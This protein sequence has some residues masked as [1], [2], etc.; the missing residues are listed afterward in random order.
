MQMYEC[1][2]SKFFIE[3][4]LFQKKL[5]TRSD[6]GFGGSSLNIFSLFY[7]EIYRAKPIFFPSPIEKVKA[8][9]NLPL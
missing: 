5:S 4:Q 1:S 8:A 2:L 7:L 3:P 9:K 6:K